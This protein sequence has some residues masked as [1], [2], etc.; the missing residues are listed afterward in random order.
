MV[1]QS[2]IDYLNKE[3]WQKAKGKHI[4]LRYKECSPWKSFYLKSI[5]ARTEKII[6]GILQS[7][8]YKRL[9]CVAGALHCHWDLS[10][11]SVSSLAEGNGQSR[12]GGVEWSSAPHSLQSDA[13][14]FLMRDTWCWNITSMAKNWT[15]SL[16]PTPRRFSTCFNN[17]QHIVQA[18]FIR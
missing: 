13:R 7:L 16:P 8:Q 3:Q 4:Q 5:Q 17:I 11:K 18:L 14:A 6:T 15:I 10:A 12:V 2:R 1:A 9:V